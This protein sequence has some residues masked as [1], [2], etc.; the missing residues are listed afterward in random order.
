MT[1]KQAELLTINDVMIRLKVSRWKVYQLI[2]SGQLHSVHFGKSHRIHSDD[3]DRYMDFLR[4]GEP[5]QVIHLKD[6]EI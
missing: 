2:N 5:E 3:L 6:V 4:T 1:N